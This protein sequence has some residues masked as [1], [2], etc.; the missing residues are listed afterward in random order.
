[1]FKKTLFSFLTVI[2]FLSMTIIQQPAYISY[3]KDILISSEVPVESSSQHGFSSIST[4]G[5][6][7]VF[8]NSNGT[9]W[10]WGNNWHGQLGDGSTKNKNKRINVSGIKNIAAIAA[11]TEHTLALTEDGAVWAWGYNNSGQLGDF[12]KLNKLSPVKVSRLSAIKKIAA[13]GLFSAAVDQ[14]GAVWVWGD[15]TYGQLGL[16]VSNAVYAEIMPSIENVKSVA[17]GFGH[18]IMLKEDGT[19]WACGYNEYGQLGNGTNQNSITPVQVNGLTSVKAIAAGGYHSLAVKDDGTAWFWGSSFCGQ[20]GDGN[21][22]I[23]HN[24]TQVSILTNIESIAGGAYHSLA[25]KEDG[26]VWAWGSNSNG[27]I[28]EGTSGNKVVP[29][30]V[31]GL[32]NVKSIAAGDYH[33]VALKNDQTVWTWGWN[34][35]GQLGD[36]TYVNRTTPVLTDGDGEI[37]DTNPPAITVNG[38]SDGEDYMNAVLPEILISDSE[39]GISSKEIL[40]NGSNYISGTIITDAGNHALYVSAV[41]NAGNTAFTEVNFK[42]YKPTSMEVTSTS[43]DYS[44]EFTIKALLMSDGSPIPDKK[45]TFIING[46]VHG[47][48][49]TTADGYAEF[50]AIQDLPQG[51]YPFNVIFTKDNTSFLSSCEAIGILNVRPENAFVAYT[52][53]LTVKYSDSVELSAKVIQEDDLCPGNLSLVNVNFTVELENSDGSKTDI[54]TY[55]AQCDEVGDASIKIPLEVGVYSVKATIVDNDF[56]TTNEDNALLSVYN[57]YGGFAIGGGWIDSNNSFYFSRYKKSSFGFTVRYKN[58]KPTGN[59]CF[60]N[61]NGK[62]CFKSTSIDWLIISSNGVQFQGVG[63]IPGHYGKYTHQVNANDVSFFHGDRISI[64]IWKG[65]DLSSEPI[66]EATNASVRGGNIAVKSW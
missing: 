8:L 15:N 21:M 19:V 4:G 27:Q 7:S 23:R 56:F 36:S 12:S 41:D 28:G 40:L 5:T 58:G 24:P 9:V 51:D 61:F 2:A 31:K 6:H 49:T 57:P 52:G 43:S 59:L 46:K 33:S 29:V 10:T 63:I 50:T 26:T 34:S 42:I 54:G 25:L 3:A 65:N 47:N 44:D 62:M 22:G 38:V 32:S 55:Q 37:T 35:Y 18:L 39:S 30:Q 13:G 1:M 53:Q 66:Y 17:A 11:G 60:Q 16:S 45:Q 20:A 14:D 48:I 64:R